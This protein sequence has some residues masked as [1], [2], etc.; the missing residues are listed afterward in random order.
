MKRGQAKLGPFPAHHE[1]KVSPSQLLREN[2]IPLMLSNLARASIALNGA[3]FPLSPAA[4]WAEDGERPNLHWRSM[5]LLSGC[6]EKF[7][8]QIHVARGYV[9][10]MLWIYWFGWF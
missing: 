6:W 8:P 4:A 3:L 9:K 2:P 7:Y 5:Q 10:R 1:T